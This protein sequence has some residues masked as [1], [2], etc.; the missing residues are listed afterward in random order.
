MLSQ[1]ECAKRLKLL[2]SHIGGNHCNRSFKGMSMHN[3][4]R[5]T[6]HYYTLATFILRGNAITALFAVQYISIFCNKSFAT[7]IHDGHVSRHKERT[8]NPHLVPLSIASERWRGTQCG[9]TQ[10]KRC[11][12]SRFLQLCLMDLRDD[13]APHLQP[14]AMWHDSDLEEVYTP[15][16]SLKP[17]IHTLTHSR[18][19][20]A[21]QG[22]SNQSAETSL[23]SHKLKPSS[24]SPSVSW[25]NNTITECS[26]R[27]KL[28]LSCSWPQFDLFMCYEEMIIA[29]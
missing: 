26:L 29:I 14:E 24:F 13:R 11:T 2:F 10:G 5:E 15:G 22:Q 4:K 17:L 1:L 23:L 3:L 25:E 18:P 28:S 9:V 6:E 16:R 19:L 7:V 21:Y 12:I 20:H 27:K 8:S